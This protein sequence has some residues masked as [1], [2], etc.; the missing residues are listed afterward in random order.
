MKTVEE[1]IL[2][3]EDPVPANA[4]KIGSVGKSNRNPR[5]SGK[6]PA[7]KNDNKGVNVSEKTLFFLWKETRH[8]NQSKCHGA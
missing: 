3:N 5:K 4:Y 7:P 2:P 6:P 8:T 1:P